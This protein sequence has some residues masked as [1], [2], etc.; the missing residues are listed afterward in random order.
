[1]KNHETTEMGPGVQTHFIGVISKWDSLIHNTGYSAND[2]SIGNYAPQCQKS[3]CLCLASFLALK[4]TWKPDPVC[5][6]VCGGWTE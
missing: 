3:V 2:K 5:P 4:W 6:L 1:M